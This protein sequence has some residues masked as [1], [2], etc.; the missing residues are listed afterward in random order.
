MSRRKRERSISFPEPREPDPGIEGAIFLAWLLKIGQNVQLSIAEK[1]WNRKRK[2]NPKL[3]DVDLD[4]FI[5]QVG[6]EYLYVTIWKGEK[7]L[8]L[9]KKG[10]EWAEPW[11]HHYNVCRGH[12]SQPSRRRLD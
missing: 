4:A 7:I 6:K 10:I 2:N 1:V 12:H 9:T 11:T 3:R 5:A 8:K